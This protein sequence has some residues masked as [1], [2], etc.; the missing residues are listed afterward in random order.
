MARI[1]LLPT[2]MLIDPVVALNAEEAHH[3]ESVG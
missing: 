3:A 1:A 2:G